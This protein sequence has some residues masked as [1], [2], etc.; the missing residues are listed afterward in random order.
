[1]AENDLSRIKDSKIPDK[2]N[3][4]IEEETADKKIRESYSDMY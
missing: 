4:E 1:M 2:I 3:T